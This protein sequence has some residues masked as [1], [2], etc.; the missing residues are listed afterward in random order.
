MKIEGP[1]RTETAGSARKAGAAA[2]P[3][4]AVP[5]SSASGPAPIAETAPSAALGSLLALQAQLY[6][7][8]RKG[9]QVKRGRAVL[10]ALDALMRATLSG[11]AAH[12][13]RLLLVKLQGEIEFTG[14]P[15]LDA[16]LAEID[17]RAAVEL[18]KLDMAE[19]RAA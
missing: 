18:A 1:R 2:A 11:E 14:D 3:G 16:I 17:L 4:F 5:T 12:G 7:P 19:Q 15:K 13:P 6:D 10:D 9:R 8:N